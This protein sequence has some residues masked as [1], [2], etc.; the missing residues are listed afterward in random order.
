MKHGSLGLFIFQG[1]YLQLF[2]S[3]LSVFLCFSNIIC[4]LSYMQHMESTYIDG[5]CIFSLANAIK[6]IPHIIYCNVI[7]YIHYSY[8]LCYSSCLQSPNSK[9]P[10]NSINKV[11]RLYL[12]ALVEAASIPPRWKQNTRTGP[13]A[14]IYSH[15]LAFK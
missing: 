9:Q 15:F 6:P 14:S 4:S 2:S 3:Y 11:G 13:N 10:D 12:F 1:V 8:P 7:I 5:R